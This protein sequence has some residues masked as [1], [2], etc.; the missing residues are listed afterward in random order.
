MK[1]I[2]ELI[3]VDTLDESKQAEI[4]E[5]LESIIEVKVDEKVQAKLTEKEST[6][7]E[8]LTTVYEEKFEEYKE[9]ITE[10]FSNFIDD[11]LEKEIVMDEKVI[12]FARK[13]ELYADLIEQFKTRLAIDEGQIDEEVKDILREARDE[14]TSLN[15]DLDVEVGKNLTLE[16]T[17]NEGKAIVYLL[18]KVK[19]LPVEDAEKVLSLLEDE[20][21]TETI[22]R[23]YD[24]IVETI[25]TEKKK[26]DE[27]DEDDEGDEG[28]EDGDEDKKKKKKKKIK[29]SKNPTLME[30]WANTMKKETI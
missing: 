20:T 4:T 18:E 29:E 14:I 16:S 26:E 3:N 21:D 24:A 5:K 11:I 6:L 27:D 9:D 22:D 7:K 17:V 15:S 12:E 28:D 13:G 23:K 10:K 1:K 2:L 25:L 30:Q 8:E 19:G